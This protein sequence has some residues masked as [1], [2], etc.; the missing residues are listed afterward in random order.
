MTKAACLFEKSSSPLSPV[1]Q[2]RNA[3][4]D[5]CQRTR[6]EA[7]YAALLHSGETQS[8]VESPKS[9]PGRQ[10]LGKEVMKRKRSILFS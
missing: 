10:K 6:A 3:E 8:H 9:E 2:R 1:P 4:G 7:F 5:V